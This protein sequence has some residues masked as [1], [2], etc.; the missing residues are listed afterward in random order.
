MIL[1]DIGFKS[2]LLLVISKSSFF[3]SRSIT[4]FTIVPSFP[5]ILSAAT[6]KF[7]AS[8]SIPSTL[9]ITSPDWIPASSAGLPW[10]GL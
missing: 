9:I 4:S 10:I 7:F 2:T 5:L 3:P 1:L 8:Y 6:F